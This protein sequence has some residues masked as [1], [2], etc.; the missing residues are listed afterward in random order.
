MIELDSLK[1]VYYHASCPDGTASA[2]IVASA[3][4]LRGLLNNVE[5]RSIQYGTK[6]HDELVPEPGSMFVDITPPLK[7]W[8]EWEGTGV[9]VLDHHETARDATIGLGGV[10][11]TNDEWSGARL[12][13]EHV[14]KPVAD[15]LS[16]YL[17]DFSFLAMIRDTWKKDHPRWKE[18]E[19]QAMAL[20]FYGSKEMLERVSHRNLD[21]EGLMCLGQALA[22][23]AEMS[24]KKYVKGS[25]SCSV[26]GISIAFFNITE[27]IT[28]DACNSLIESGNDV[29]VGF[30]MISNNGRPEWSISLR[31]KSLPVNTIAAAHGGGGHRL[32]AGFRM[33]GFLSIRDVMFVIEE[34][35]KSLISSSLEYGAR[36]TM[37]EV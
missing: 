24:I 10:Y 35:V 6:E 23:K 32:A 27:G 19:A 25:W 18:A 37:P 28:S 36:E 34:G 31:S 1:R 9:V 30:F 5:F 26:D 7:R 20:S 4:S 3:L 11:G 14:F 8:R 12:A 33:D 22:K 2:V 17:D 21:L 13:H 16:E 15:G 29:A